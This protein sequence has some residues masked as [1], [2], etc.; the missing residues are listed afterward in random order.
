V[1]ERRDP[2]AA[3]TWSYQS[4]GQPQIANWD[5]SRALSY[6]YYA[7]TFVY[8]CVQVRALA[9]ASLPIRVGADPSKPNDY[10]TRN[11]LA[12]LLRPPPGGPNRDITAQSLIAW[13]LA[14]L[15]VTGRVGWELELGSGGHAGRPVPAA[16]P[17]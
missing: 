3:T 14:Q 11:P 17:T 1:I 5:A 8:R 7:N 12:R 16:V 4:P 6:G 2:K 15:D 9:L 13:S 10:D